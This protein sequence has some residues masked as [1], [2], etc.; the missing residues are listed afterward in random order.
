MEFDCPSPSHDIHPPWGPSCSSLTPFALFT[1][2]LRDVLAGISQEIIL[3]GGQKSTAGEDHVWWA[4]RLRSRALT[5]YTGI[6]SR[7]ANSRTKSINAR[8]AAETTLLRFLI[9]LSSS[10]LLSLA[11]WTI[12]F[13]K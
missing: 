4:H 2:P 5:C 7:I 1:K 12:L 3:S 10:S 11:Y 8:L 6:W 9:A 13:P